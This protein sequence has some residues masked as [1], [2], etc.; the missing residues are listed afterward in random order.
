[1]NLRKSLIDLLSS[2]KGVDPSNLTQS[3]RNNI[4]LLEQRIMYSATQLGAA[5]GGEAGIDYD[6]FENLCCDSGIQ[7]LFGKFDS[8]VDQG[9]IENFVDD[10]FVEEAGSAES[11]AQDVYFGGDNNT[12]PGVDIHGTSLSLIHI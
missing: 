5:L 10:L 2:S 1:M 12:T 6:Q 4:E 11:F 3:Q 8:N 9:E 7:E